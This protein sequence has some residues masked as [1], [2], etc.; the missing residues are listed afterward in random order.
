VRAGE[1]G[2]GEVEEHEAARSQVAAGERALDGVLARPQPVEGAI[3][4]V[5][6]AG[7]YLKVLPQAGIGE[8]AATGQLGGGAQHAGADEGEGQ[9]ALAAGGPEDL[10]E[11]QGPGLPIDG[12][13]IPVGQGA[14][15]LEGF[16]GA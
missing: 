1:V 2:G 15:D 12:D 5:A 14:R 8:V 11:A 16:L 13:R 7:A 9:F 4:G 10:G 6:V 3:Q